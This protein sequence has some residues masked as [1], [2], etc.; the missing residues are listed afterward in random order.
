[1]NN[2]VTTCCIH[3]PED[4]P[5]ITIE[6]G[7]PIVVD[8]YSEVGFYMGIHFDIRSDEFTRV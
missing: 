4:N 3:I 6:P 1:M 7:T 8:E 2:A 5:F